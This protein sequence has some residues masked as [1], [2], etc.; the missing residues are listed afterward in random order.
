VSNNRDQVLIEKCRKGDRRALEEL[1]QTYQRPVYNAAYRMLGN[2]D[3]AADVA[4]ASFLKVFENLERYNPNYK[5]FSWIYRI[6]INESIDRI[7]KGKKQQ[8]LDESQASSEP[9][10]ER[11]ADSDDRSRRVQAVL[12]GLPEDYRTVVVLRHF[13]DCSYREISEVLHIPEKTVKSRLYT[14]RQQMKDML[15]A[16]GVL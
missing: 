15:E 12:M 8:V 6:A 7:N 3:E 5:F 9:G 4:Q 13:S 2:A 1:V 11:L 16:E 14:A 10:P